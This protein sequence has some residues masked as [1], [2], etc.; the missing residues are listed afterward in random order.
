MSFMQ[1]FGA[2]IIALAVYAVLVAVIAVY[3][4]WKRDEDETLMIC[5]VSGAV[6]FACLFIAW[7]MGVPVPEW[8]K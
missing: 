3:G 5:L 7:Y 2:T 6:L 4:C 1:V 8:M